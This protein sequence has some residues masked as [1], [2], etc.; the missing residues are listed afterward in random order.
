MM[1]RLLMAIATCG[2]IGRLEKAPGTWGSVAAFVPW[3]FIRGC[4]LQT[5]LAILA[6]IFIIGFFAAGA[7]EKI[8]DRPDPACIVIDEMFGMLLALTAAPDH[9]AAWLTAFILFRIFDISKPFPVSWID[10]HIHGGLG[11]MLDDAAAGIYALGCLQVISAF[12]R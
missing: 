1:D 6:G 3:L 5:Y 9:P 10:R 8:L 7:A 2:P 12:V 4:D 11:I